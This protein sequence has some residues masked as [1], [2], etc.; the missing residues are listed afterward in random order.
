M[1][2]RL[3]RRPLEERQRFTLQR[4]LAPPIFKIDSKLSL[5]LSVVFRDEGS[6]EVQEHTPKHAE[7]PTPL[8]EQ[9]PN[10]PNYQAGNCLQHSAL[11]F[12]KIVK[13]ILSVCLN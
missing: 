4:V 3:E 1:Q 8:R 2:Q 13:I 9:L 10:Q 11:Q 7:T 5:S 12:S 6:K